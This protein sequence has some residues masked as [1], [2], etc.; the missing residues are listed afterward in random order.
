VLSTVR[1]QFM[2]QDELKRMRD[3]IADPS[4]ETGQRQALRREL[5][6]L[7]RAPLEPPPRPVVQQ[8]SASNG[9]V[10]RLSGAVAGD[11][12]PAPDLA[13]AGLAAMLFAF[14]GASVCLLAIPDRR[15]VGNSPAAP[16]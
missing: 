9:I 14:A 8:P 11:A 12:M 7:R 6:A 1:A 2:K 13:W 15:G 5:R 16:S 4:L 3:Q 10:D